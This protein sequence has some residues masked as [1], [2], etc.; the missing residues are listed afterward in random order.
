MIRIARGTKIL[1]SVITSEILAFEGLG[2]SDLSS[3]YIG[4]I[5]KDFVSK[6]PGKNNKKNLDNWSNGYLRCLSC[7]YEEISGVTGHKTIHTK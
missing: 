5:C 1:V 7:N 6:S 2:G 3:F 4:F